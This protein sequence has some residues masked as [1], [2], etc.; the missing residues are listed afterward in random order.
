MSRSFVSHTVVSLATLSL[1]SACGTPAGVS[2]LDNTSPLPT[3]KQQSIR[4]QF[5]PEVNGAPFRCGQSYTG[6]G[7]TQSTLTPKDFRLYVS[8]VHLMTAAGEAV[9]LTLT[10]NAWQHHNLALLDFEDKTGD[11]ESGT[12]ATN[13]EITGTVPAGDYT[14]IQF[15]LGVPFDMNHQDASTA[16]APLNLTSMFW[17]WRFGY[18]F[19]RIDFATTG[20]PQGYFI[21]LGSTGCTGN[22]DIPTTAPLQCENPNRGQITL[23]SFKPDND[24]IVADLGALL[25]DSDIDVN[26]AESAAG[27]MSGNDD[28]DCN[29][30]LPALGVDFNGTPAQQRLFSVRS[31]Q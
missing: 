15:E 23:N 8:Q 24:V 25:Q 31:A 17:V 21:H 19:T 26:Q 10:P 16:P 4:I 9:P 14:G 27:C 20:M 3:E 30:I 12:S 5:A 2:S 13:L 29:A 1:L 22:S 6:V 11:C 7:T 28:A 18:K